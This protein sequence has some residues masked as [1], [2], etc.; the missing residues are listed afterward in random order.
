MS[1]FDLDRDVLILIAAVVRI[2][3]RKT[4]EAVAGGA[5]YFYHPSSNVMQSVQQ[6]K[7]SSQC[8]ATPESSALERKV[9]S[10]HALM[11][12]Y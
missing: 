10:N 11:P 7:E 4:S 9:Q 8:Q 5:L 2:W 6:S 3:L 12:M 1:P